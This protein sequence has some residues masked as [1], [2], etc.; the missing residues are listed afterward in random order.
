MATQLQQPGVERRNCGCSDGHPLPV[1][2][3]TLA[4]RGP[5]HRPQW[6]AYTHHDHGVHVR[7]RGVGGI[8]LLLPH[9][10]DAPLGGG[11]CAICLNRMDLH[12]VHSQWR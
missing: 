5:T 9:L 1:L 3:R 4:P 6:V 11:V 2:H 10:Y 12:Y 7:L 8:A